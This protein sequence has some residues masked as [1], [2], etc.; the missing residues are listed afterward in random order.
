MSDK[1]PVVIKNTTPHEVSFS[2]VTGKIT[3]KVNR[4]N[5]GAAAEAGDNK[6]I[7]REQTADA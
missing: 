3:R 4:F 5:D 7:L 1:A 2:E 6:E